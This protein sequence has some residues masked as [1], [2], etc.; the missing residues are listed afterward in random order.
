MIIPFTFLQGCALFLAAML[1]GALNSVAGGGSFISF[2]TL[3]FTGVPPKLGNATNTIALWP[4]SI[5][6]VGAYREELQKMGW[7]PRRGGSAGTETVRS[8][9][10]RNLLIV[11]SL[12]GG[13]LGAILLLVTPEST[14]GKLLPWLLLFAVL[15]F[16][17]GKRG[18][19]YLRASVG[20]MSISS[21]TLE[22]GVLAAQFFVAVYGGFFG[23][24]IGIMMLAVLSLAGMQNIHQMN[25]IKTLLATCI[26]GMAV[27]AF[28]LAHQIVWAQGL[29]M[30]VGAIMGGYFGAFF[31]QRIN[32]AL[33]R[34]FVIAVGVLMTIYFFYKMYFGG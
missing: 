14:F 2:P 29:L 11:I 6:S 26:N 8:V 19:T 24:G 21:G 15:L 9:S 20:R 18:S 12:I 25:G 3:L 17:F 33:V 16:A 22:I 7:L 1:A 31:A 28:I 13:V 23:G 30:V 5:A 32:P 10:Y 27:A 34:Y 4:G